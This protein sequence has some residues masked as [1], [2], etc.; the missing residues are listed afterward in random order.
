[1]KRLIAAVLAVLFTLS[2]MTGCAESS[3]ATNETEPQDRFQCVDFA[4]G[5]YSSCVYVDMETGVLY[6]GRDT[7]D[8]T[9]MTVLLNADG[10]PMIWEGWEK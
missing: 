7:K 9:F 4:T 8:H 5:I 3:E 1:M 10:T 2:V 6:L